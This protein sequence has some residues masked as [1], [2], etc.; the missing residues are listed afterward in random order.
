ME[1]K[2][3]A[4]S[5]GG[6]QGV[7]THQSEACGVPMTFAVF[8][9]QHAPGE[10]LPVL[11]YLSG[12][13]CTHANVMEKGEYRAAAAKHRVIIVCPD[14]SPRGEGVAD[15]ADNWKMG[16]GAGF[17]VDAT[18]APL[19]GAL[20]DVFLHQHRTAKACGQQFSG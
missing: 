4:K 14:T 9:P 2:S 15:V 1:T 18:E 13:T 17:Y 5:H 12:L 7:Y 11:W 19:V 20:Q 16:C 10:K 8:V 6:V 3:T